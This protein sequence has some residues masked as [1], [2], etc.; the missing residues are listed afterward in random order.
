MVVDGLLSSFSILGGRRVL[1]F[2]SEGNVIYSG[3]NKVLNIDCCSLS[4]LKV[5]KSKV[6]VLR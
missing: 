4:A 3:Q 1:E 6:F 5:E 2:S